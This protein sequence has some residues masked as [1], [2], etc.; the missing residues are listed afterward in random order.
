MGGFMTIDE[1]LEA[2][3]QSMEVL[4]G[5]HLDNDKRFTEQIRHLAVIAE[6][7]E[8][9]AGQMIDAIRSLDNRTGQIMDAIHSLDKRSGQMMDAIRSLAR[10]M[11]N[12]EQRI[13]ELE[14]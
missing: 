6:Q 11:E 4:Q 13:D 3:T 9:R 1:R 14:T 2:L 12:H 5:M 7:N 8:I 10:V